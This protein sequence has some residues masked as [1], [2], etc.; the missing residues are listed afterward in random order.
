ML[1]TSV[2]SPTRTRARL[3]SMGVGLLACAWLVQCGDP[4]LGAAQL[5]AKIDSTTVFDGSTLEMPASADGQTVATDA[6][7][8]TA[9]DQEATG[10]GPSDLGWTSSD[11]SDAVIVPTDSGV[12]D[13]AG[14]GKDTTATVDANGFVPFAL[15]SA[16]PPDGASGLAVP[17]QLSWKFNQQVKAVAASAY[18][19]AVTGSDGQPID[20]TFGAS[21]DTITFASSSPIPPASRVQVVLGV[22]V[23]AQKGGSLDSPVTFKYYTTGL[24][25]MGK[26]AQLARRYA[27]IWRQGVLSG[28]DLPMAPDFDGDWHA[29][30]NATG[31]AAYQALADVAW[32]VIETQSHYFLTY[33]VYWPSR[34]GLPPGVAADNDTAGAQIAVRKWPSEAPIALTT[35]FKAKNDEQM[36]LW[37][38]PDNGLSSQLGSFVRAILP[39][40]TLFPTVSDA[41]DTYGCE[42]MVGCKPRRALLYLTAGT[43]QSCLWAD[44]GNGSGLLAIPQCVVNQDLKTKGLFV[45]YLPGAI[46]QAPG[47]AAN[48][49]VT[50]HYSLRALHDVWWPHRD[51]AG[52]DGLWQDALYVYTP[53]TG[54]P[55]GSTSGIGSKFLSAQADFGRPPWAWAWKPSGNTTYYDLPRGTPVLDPAYALAA[56]TLPQ[57][58]KASYDP[59]TKTG[60]SLDYCLHP[61][62]FID[63][64]SSAPCQNNL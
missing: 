1:R 18:T 52:T 12:S 53:P 42:G 36:W 20:G 35:W 41:T 46:A 11:V 24:G 32:T 21:G 6:D 55:S 34:P 44:A 64:R 4:P 7:S 27:P 23:Q 10:Q 14:P 63:L 16:D 29:S 2:D 30:N 17:L 40:D 49:A 13:V 37:L 47:N 38:T 25:D 28:A 58:S 15:V 48:P 3:R 19:I 45:D 62:W 43:H 50:T 39:T 59:S 61:L 54:R 57:A 51:E 33:T 8:T 5:D 60:F 22:L 56:R 31:T 9:A 26:Y